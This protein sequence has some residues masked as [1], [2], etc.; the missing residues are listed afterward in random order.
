MHTEMLMI[1]RLLWLGVTLR[2]VKQFSANEVRHTGLSSGQNYR[3]SIHR[4]KCWWWK[5]SK[6]WKFEILFPSITQTVSLMSLMSLGSIWTKIPASMPGKKKQQDLLSGLTNLQNR[7][8]AKATSTVWKHHA[9]YTNLTNLWPFF[10]VCKE[11]HETA[12]HIDN[13]TGLFQMEPVWMPGQGSNGTAFAFCIWQRYFE[14]WLVW[15]V[16]QKHRGIHKHISLGWNKSDDIWIKKTALSVQQFWFA[17]L[18]AKTLH[19]PPQ[20]S[21]LCIQ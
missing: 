21:I 7:R 5:V 9:Q 1:S 2:R 19:P 17:A 18:N 3:R 16:F 12:Y 11:Q 10:M 4:S 14:C 13:W 20:F 15:Q 6:S 8:D